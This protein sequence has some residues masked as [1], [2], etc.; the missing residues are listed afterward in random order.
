MKG[1]ET[2]HTT[3]RVWELFLQG[4]S[5]PQI[6][7]ELGIPKSSASSAVARGRQKGHLPPPRFRYRMS[8]ML[9]QH[10]M[11]TGNMSDIFNNLT[12]DQRHWV[13]D[14]A[15]RIGCETVAEYIL[16]LL[17]DGHEERKVE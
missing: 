9:K 10:G 5:V 7:D 2:K 15:E 3:Q 6:A 16:E 1:A 4:K 14:Q 17:R 11:Y 8:Y 12:V 13:I